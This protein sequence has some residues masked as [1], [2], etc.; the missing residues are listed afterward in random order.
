MPEGVDVEEAKE[1]I[2]E[3]GKLNIPYGGSLPCQFL[4]SFASLH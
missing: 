3:M 4:L 2:A 1:K